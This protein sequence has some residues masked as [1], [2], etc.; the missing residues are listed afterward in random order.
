MIHFEGYVGWWKVARLNSSAFFFWRVWTFTYFFLLANANAEYKTGLLKLTGRHCHRFVLGWSF[1]VIAASATSATA[2]SKRA[3]LVTN[4]ILLFWVYSINNQ[5]KEVFFTNTWSK[6]APIV[7]DS[8]LGP[9]CLL[10]WSELTNPTETPLQ[11]LL[12]VNRINFC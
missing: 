10:E 7:F 11:K 3:G 2:S 4:S 5:V 8:V 12:I 9:T 1:A 6:F